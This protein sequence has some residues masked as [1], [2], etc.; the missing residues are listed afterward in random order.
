M[1]SSVFFFLGGKRAIR[2]PWK[3]E[4]HTHMLVGAAERDVSL[5]GLGVAER[6]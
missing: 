2:R 5:G 1:V 4:G 6:P 3:R